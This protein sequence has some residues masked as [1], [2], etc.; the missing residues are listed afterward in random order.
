[1][2]IDLFSVLVY[3]VLVLA[4]GML[5]GHFR[6]QNK[7]HPGYAHLCLPFLSPG[8]RHTLFKIQRLTGMSEQAEFFKAARTH[9]SKGICE[10]IDPL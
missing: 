7:E 1:M 9:L 3:L 8:H 4:V 5:A 2:N 6:H 10:D